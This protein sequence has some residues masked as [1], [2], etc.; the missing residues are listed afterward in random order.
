MIN[1]IIWPVLLWLVLL[2]VMT[3]LQAGQTPQ[4]LMGPARGA[5]APVG[6]FH[7]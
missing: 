6:A 3:D 5:L 7:I 4:Q 1:V 2:P